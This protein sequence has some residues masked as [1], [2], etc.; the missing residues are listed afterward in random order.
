MNARTLDDTLYW[1]D[2]VSMFMNMLTI[3]GEEN[4]YGYE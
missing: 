2:T 1:C 3:L 4:F